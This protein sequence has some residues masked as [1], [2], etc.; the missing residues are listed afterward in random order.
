MLNV[1]N[2]QTSPVLDI[3]IVSSFG[4]KTRQELI[5]LSSQNHTHQEFVI[6]QLVCT[7]CLSLTEDERYLLTSSGEVLLDTLKHNI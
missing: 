5:G 4:P 3:L 1:K 2:N 7:G 6:E